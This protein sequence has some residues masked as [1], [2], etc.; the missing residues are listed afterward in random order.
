MYSNN[1]LYLVRKIGDIYFIVL[2]IAQNLHSANIDLFCVIHLRSK[3]VQP[4][5]GTFKIK[6]PMSLPTMLN[7]W[8]NHLSF[9]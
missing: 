1:L 3:Q 2:K 7:L 6:C 4:E 8:K 5:K 9:A